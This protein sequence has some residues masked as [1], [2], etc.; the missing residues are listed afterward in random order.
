MDDPDPPTQYAAASVTGG[1]KTDEKDARVLGDVSRIDL[2]SLH[3]PSP[4]SREVKSVCASREV[5]KRTAPRPL[6]R[7]DQTSA[8]LARS[9]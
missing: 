3:T 9:R 2:P 1:V 5:L 8:E 4:N 6:A 7:R